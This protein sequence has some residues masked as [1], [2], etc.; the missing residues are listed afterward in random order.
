MIDILDDVLKLLTYRSFLG[1]LKLGSQNSE[2]VALPGVQEAGDQLG[3]SDGK[4]L[5][6]GQSLKMLFLTLKQT[7]NVIE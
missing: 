6:D 7:S 2:N 1:L 5:L 4:C 3:R